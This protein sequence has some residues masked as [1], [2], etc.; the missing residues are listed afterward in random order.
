[1]NLFCR[2][3][4]NSRVDIQVKTSANVKTLYCHMLAKGVMV[5]SITTSFKRQTAEFSFTP[6]FDYAPYLKLIFFFYD[7]KGMIVAKSNLIE[8]YDALPNYVS[9]HFKNII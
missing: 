9:E 2:P 8:L 5:K 7:D 3:K 4:L 1:M 6:T